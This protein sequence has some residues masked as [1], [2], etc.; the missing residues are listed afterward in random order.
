MRER[1]AMHETL[2]LHEL[3]SFKSVCATKAA[4]MSNMATD[5]ALRSLLQQ[6]LQMAKKHINDLQN[7]LQKHF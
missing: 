7:L 1:L 6:D 3:I 5:P 4:A 2:D